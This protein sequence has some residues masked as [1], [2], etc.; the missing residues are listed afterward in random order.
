MTETMMEA[1]DRLGSRRRAKV[2]I[3]LAKSRDPDDPAAIARREMPRPEY[4]ELA[5]ALGADLVSFDD[6]EASPHPAVRA[7]WQLGARFGLAVIGLLRRREFDLIYATGEDVGLPLAALLRGVRWNGRLTMV[8]HQCDTPKRRFLVGALGHRVWR[9]I[10]VLASEQRRVLVHDL[11]LPPQK[12]HRFG[13]WLDTTFFDPSLATVPSGSYALSC[14][15]E[16]R[17][18]ATLEAAVSDLPYRVHVAASG[19]APHAGFNAA[20]GVRPSSTITVSSGH[21]SYRELR[22]LYAGARFVITPLR[23]VT[24]AAGV[25]SICEAMAMGK[26]VIASDSPGIRDYVTDGVSGLVVPVGDAGALRRAI[27]ELWESL[28]RCAAMGERNRRWV[29]EHAATRHYV[30][31]VVALMDGAH[32]DA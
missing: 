10:I 24:Y 27:Q 19:W 8:A 26:A 29:R 15:R 13:Q 1:R 9:G 22:D 28:E 17:D 6:V 32:H 12:V 5:E 23:S 7:A 18:Y 16:S 31:S 2:L 3:L 14:G 11:A 20:G 30:E 4:V 25:T 21:L